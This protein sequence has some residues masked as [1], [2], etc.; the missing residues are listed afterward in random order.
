MLDL[1][2]VDVD[3]DVSTLEVLESAG[4]IE[5]EV[6]HD[7]GFHIFDIMAGLLDLSIEFVVLGVVDSGEDVVQWS[8]PNFGVVFSS[9]CLEEDQAFGG[10]LDQDGDDDQFPAGATCVWVA[11]CGSAAATD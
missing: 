1:L 7:D 10:V 6:A 9:A 5:V 8:A 11:G 4:V 3:R 2:L